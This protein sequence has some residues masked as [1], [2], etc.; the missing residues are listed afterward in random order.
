MKIRFPFF[1][2]LIVAEILLFGQLSDHFGFLQTLA[3]YWLPTFLIAALVPF[4]AFRIQSFVRS[5]RP[6][7]FDPSLRRHLHQ[8]MILLGLLLWFIPLMSFRVFGLFFVLPGFR[9]LFVRRFQK[10]LVQLADRYVYPGGPGS[11][12]QFS[13]VRFGNSTETYTPM[14]GPMKDVR[15]YRPPHI[16]RPDEN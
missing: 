15:P 2:V 13:F 16:T 8:L 11:Q 7:A 10:A 6:Q 5:P 4:W 1:L 12:F 14:Q 9:H 3:L